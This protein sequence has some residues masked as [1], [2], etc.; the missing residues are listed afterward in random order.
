M[1]LNLVCGTENAVSNV[2]EPSK[3]VYEG[4]FSTPA[5]CDLHRAQALNL[6]ME[7]VEEKA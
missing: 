7:A 1:Q 3:C 4:T 5:A 6:D 2:I